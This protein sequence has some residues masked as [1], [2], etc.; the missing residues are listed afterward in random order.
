MQRFWMRS[1]IHAVKTANLSA[2]KLNAAWTYF[3]LFFRFSRVS[4][5]NHMDCLKKSSLWR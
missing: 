1:V 4:F 3:I 2:T 5:F